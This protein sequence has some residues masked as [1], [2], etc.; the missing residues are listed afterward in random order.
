MIIQNSRK[1]MN[2]L[3]LGMFGATQNKPAFGFGSTATAAPT[4]SFGFSN[5][6]GSS[7]FNNQP[8][9]GGLFG[10]TTNTGFGANTTG[11]FGGFGTNFSAGGGLTGGLNTTLQQPQAPQPQYTVI[12]SPPKKNRQVNSLVT[13]KNVSFTKF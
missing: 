2:Y 13:S 12:L 1:L 10:N 5:T 11:G 9:P 4:Q 6:G 8:K 3:V 7:L